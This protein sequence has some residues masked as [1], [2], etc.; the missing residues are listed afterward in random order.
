[1]RENSKIRPLFVVGVFWS[2]F[3]LIGCAQ[4]SVGRRMKVCFQWFLAEFLLGQQSAVLLYKKV[5][6]HTSVVVK[7][8]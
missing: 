2:N 3:V 4:D 8:T 5:R 7:C 6:M 1:M